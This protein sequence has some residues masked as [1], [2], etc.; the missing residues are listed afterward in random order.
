MERPPSRAD[1]AAITN[2]PIAA[3]SFGGGEAMT[4]GPALRARPRVFY[5]WWMVAAAAGIQLISGAALSQAFG[6]Y[7][8]VLRDNFGWSTTS[9][10]AASS[11]REMETGIIGPAQG[12]FL[13]RFGPR[14]IC[15]LGIVIF[16]AGFLLFSQIQT[17]PQFY[18]V[19]IIMSVGLSLSGYLT[20]TYATIQWFER[21]RATALALMS[22]GGA[23]GGLLVRG[24]VAV[25][26]AY[27][28]RTTAVLSAIVILAVGLP[29]AQVIRFRPTDYGLYPDGDDPADGPRRAI[30][31]HYEEPEGTRDFT[32]REAMRTRAFWFVSLGHTSALFV[33]AALNVHLITHLK[34]GLGYSLGA[35]STIALVLPL[36]FLVGT[37]LGGPFGDRFSKR[38]LAVGCLFAH[39]VAILML[40]HVTS[41]ALILTAAVIHGLAWGL[42]GPQMAALR[43]DYFGRTAFATI[44]GVSN[45]I[46]IIGTI[47]GPIIAGL[48]Y[49]QT[50]S[51]RTGFD[52]LAALAAAGSLF[53]ILAPRPPRPLVEAPGEVQG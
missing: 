25:I 13:S 50:G 51:Y 10:A 15:Q 16:A 53:F 37:L 46:I 41:Q 6:A 4:A 34:E 24:T 42:R 38:W 27:G 36:L 44:M 7:V 14:R 3:D 26:E 39:A 22:A 49:D 8:A 9:L 21:R 19:F 18:A 31:V 2:D 40:A 33:V 52:I 20:L 32:L 12:W 47:A 29:L 28:W 5:G 17:L 23:I 43:A 1:A 11:L 35:A 45:S 48:I 30:S